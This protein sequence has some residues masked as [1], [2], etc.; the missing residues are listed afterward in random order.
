[1]L[2][3]PADA[4]SP[5]MTNVPAPRGCARIVNRACLAAE[6][7]YR[8]ALGRVRAGFERAHD[9]CA[10]LLAKTER[11]E[12]ALAVRDEELR[13][14]RARIG[15][16]PP[17]QRR[18]YPPPHERFAILS[19]RAR[20]GWK[21]ADTA[22]RFLVTATTIAGWMKRLDERGKDALVKPRAPVNRYS[23]RVALIVK[24]LHALAPQLGKR[25][26]A[27]ILARAGIKLAASTVARLK[28]RRLAP[29]SSAPASTCGPSRR[30]SANGSER[31]VS[32]KCP[33]HLWH[34]DITTIEAIGRSLPFWPYSLFNT[35][36]FT[37]HI[38]VVV[39]HFS[40][41]FVAFG[42]FKKE[43]TGRDICRVLDDAKNKARRGRVTSSPI[44]ARSSPATT[45]HGAMRTAPTRA[46]AP[47]AS[48]A[49]SLWSS[50]SSARSSRSTCAASW[51]RSRASR[52]SLRS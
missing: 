24:K 10:R 1:L 20:T 2:L 40:R 42:V 16:L 50:A 31:V 32:A 37:W 46:S 34:V 52:S 36:P 14:L 28:K 38:V 45:S 35:W 41:A 11:L 19:L 22:R 8:V 6:A 18:H 21:L 25:K 33:H 27:D 9:P 26:V 47:S 23:D 13:I 48:T 39:D 29:P 51:C 7:L 4:Q 30:R 5:M 3:S 44:E 17:R 12:S 49:R 15:A 43:P